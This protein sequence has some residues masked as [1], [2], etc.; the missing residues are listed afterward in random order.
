MDRA[1]EDLANAALAYVARDTI[2]SLDGTS[3][4][5][6]HCKTHWYNS[7]LE[8]ISKFDWPECR[9]IQSLELLEGVDTAG[10]S[11]AYGLPSD[12]E[13]I[14]YVGQQKFTKPAPYERGMSSDITTNRQYV[15]T[16]EANAFIRYGSSRVSIARWSAESFDLIAIILAQKICMPIGKDLKLHQYLGNLYKTKLS[17][18][19]TAVA[20]SEPEVFSTDFVPETI[21]VRSA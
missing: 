12:A 10:W 2:V 11:F 21:A 4:A 19:K 14:W 15:F 3:P 13:K 20:N 6:I 9:V 1:P 18:I 17:E 16:N 8:F 7:M 5:A